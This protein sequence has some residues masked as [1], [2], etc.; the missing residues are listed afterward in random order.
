MCFRRTALLALSLTAF[1]LAT[2]WGRAV[3]GPALAAL[4]ATF[5]LGLVAFVAH[6]ARTA[7]PLVQ[8]ALLRDRALSAGL[9]SMGLVSTIMMAT[10]IV[11]PFYLSG[12]LRL[13]PVET[14]LVMSIGPGVA[15]LTGIPAG[16]LVDRLG[17]F[18]VTITGLAGVTT[19]SVLMIVLPGAFGVGGYIGGLALITAGYALFQ[20]ANTTV[21]M[22]GATNERRGV[23]S[24]LLGLSR[25][26]GLI[27]GA[28]A[29]GALFALGSRGVEM[30]G[31]GQGGEAGLQLT[32]AAAAGFA[33]LALGIAVRG[34]PRG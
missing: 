16:R 15:A 30:L 34:R 22:N 8:L 3:P 11:G 7:A 29:M 10:L 17:A 14:G 4:V 25:N 18:R 24:A 12:V 21:V 23:T 2:T 33:G 32:F 19:G 6:E 5:A 27:T 26:L 9:L 28:T 20:A 13:G 31:L 1:A